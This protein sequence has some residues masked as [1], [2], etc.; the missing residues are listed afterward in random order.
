[1]VYRLL[2]G[3]HWARKCWQRAPPGSTG[4]PGS[5]RYSRQHCPWGR[6]W[7]GCRPAG[8]QGCGRHGCTGSNW[9]GCSGCRSHLTGAEAAE[10]SGLQNAARSWPSWRSLEERDQSSSSSS[11]NTLLLRWYWRPHRQ[12]SKMALRDRGLFDLVWKASLLFFS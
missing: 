5:P 3:I 11:F 9:T 12:L 2:P 8:P 1:M 4:V 10:P 7:P 6:R